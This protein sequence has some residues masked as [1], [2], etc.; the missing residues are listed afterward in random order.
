MTPIRGLHSRA[1][2]DDSPE[3]GTQKA[4]QPEALNEEPKND[5]QADLDDVL[6]SGQ[7]R[8]YLAAALGSRSTEE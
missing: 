5:L 1:L 8:R 2:A 6:A 7:R 4:N 3:K